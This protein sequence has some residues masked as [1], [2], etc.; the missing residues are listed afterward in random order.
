MKQFKSIGPL[1]TKFRYK[2]QSVHGDSFLLSK[3]LFGAVLLSPWNLK[4]EFRETCW[5]V[6][7]SMTT[8]VESRVKSVFF[9]LF[10]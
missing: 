9:V 8:P 1:D 3:I 7:S 6:S 5:I 4:T 2:R 10:V